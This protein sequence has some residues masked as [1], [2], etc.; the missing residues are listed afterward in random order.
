MDLIQGLKRF[1]TGSLEDASTT[2]SSSRK[3]QATSR[4]HP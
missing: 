1:G 2:T 3:G 4:F